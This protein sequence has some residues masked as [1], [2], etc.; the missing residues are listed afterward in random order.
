MNK[1]YQLKTN[2]I[3]GE[4]QVIDVKPAVGKAPVKLTAAPGAR[5]ELIDASTKAA[6]DNIRVMR[7]GS[8]LQI[9]FD[10]DTEPGAVIENLYQ[11]HTDEQPTLV[12]STESGKLYEYIPESAAPSAVVAH[13]GDTGYAYGM[14]LGGAELTAGSGAAVGLLAPVVAGF[15]PVLLGAGALGAAAL[16]GGGGGS[17]GNT[18]AGGGTAKPNDGMVLGL[19]I[20]SDKDNNGY[21][22]RDEKGAASTTSITTTFDSTKVAAGQVLTV[23]DGIQIKTHTLTPDDVKA[24]KVT[25]SGW[26]LPAEDNTLT[27]KATLSDGTH[28]T[29]EATKSATLDTMSPNGDK[30]VDLRIDLDSNADGTINGSE[31]G[32]ATTTSLTATFDRNKVSMGNTVTFSDGINSKKVALTAADVDAGKVTSSGWA[33]LP[34]EN[35]T[36]TYTA[37]LSDAAGNTTPKAEQ[38]IKLDAVVESLKTALSIDPITGDNL[39][40]V[41]EQKAATITVTGKVTGTFVVG[42]VVTLLVNNKTFTGQAG[43]D[44]K[45]SINI[46]TVDLGADA[47]RQIEG[48]VT[49]GNGG[50]PAT[51]AQHYALETA[52]TAGKLT[53]LFID[54]VTADNI[55][56]IEETKNPDTTSIDV[57]GKVT[58]KF[59]AGDTVSLLVNNKTFIGTVDA[60]GTYKILVLKEDLLKDGDT[61]VDAFVTGTGGTSAKAMQ[62]YGID[63]AISNKIDLYIDLDTGNTKYSDDGYINKN[64]KAKNDTTSLTAFF[65]K[66][67]VSIGDVVTFTNI[68]TKEIK[69]VS[70][71][72]EMIAESKVTSTGWALPNEGSKLNVEAVLKDAAGN[73][74]E[75]AKDFATIDTVAATVKLSPVSQ[76]FVLERLGFEPNEAGTF[77][78]HV[79]DS[80]FSALPAGGKLFSGNTSNLE[81]PANKIFFQHWDTA[82]NSS[83]T[84]LVDDKTTTAYFVT[85]NTIFQV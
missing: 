21:I 65:D 22:N 84:Y 49:G 33:L 45:F 36:K 60:N 39:L 67:T 4:Q 17:S 62:N 77:L 74:S 40:S 10:G 38:S 44:G 18:G 71:T 14:A 76:N 5:Y 30:A 31:K 19:S 23:S 16:A 34:D 2:A 64:E 43:A 47:D 25:I 46:P 27:V 12:G 3:Q 35:G 85:P 66:S 13:L 42:E 56:N 32:L 8:N 61:T 26:A 37:V 57:T 53:S 80:V 15:S 24:G 7:K 59:A 6:P 28:T 72:A 82:G 41:D 1:T 63:I 52:N 9:F 70:L 11:A 50:Q 48:S 55:L 68:D 75:I 20:D 73:S 51:A 81:I 58:G 54:P 83:T 29:P 79:G 78:L 69:S